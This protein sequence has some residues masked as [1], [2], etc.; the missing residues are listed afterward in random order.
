M[1]ALAVLSFF[2][3]AVQG[4]SPSVDI[5]PNGFPKY[6]F[7]LEGPVSFNLRMVIRQAEDKKRKNGI[8]D[9]YISLTLPET[10][11]IVGNCPGASFR[12]KDGSLQF[13][14]EIDGEKTCTGKFCDAV[15]KKFKE[16]MGEKVIPSGKTVDLQIGTAEDGETKALISNILQPVAIPFVGWE[17]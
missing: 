1:F 12:V 2:V 11:P 6:E 10:E 4:M 17:N 8:A 3:V 13:A 9:F 7:L 14:R 15:N 5:G 16:M